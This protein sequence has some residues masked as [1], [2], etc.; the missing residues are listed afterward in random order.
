M[1]FIFVLG[2]VISGLGKGVTASSIGAILNEMGYK[3]TIK[4]LDPYLNVDPGTMNPIEHG[5]VYV[6]NDGGETDLD[7][8][9][10]ERIAEIKA[11]KNNS[12]SSGKLFFELLKKERKG[13]YLGKTVQLIPHFTNMIEEF[14]YRDVDKYDFV[15][16]EIG[17]S[18]GDY[19][20]GPFLECIRRMKKK[21]KN[22]VMICLVSYIVYYKASKESKTKPTQVAV[23][24]LMET[25]NQPDVLFARTEYD[26][27]E[28]VLNK[29]S[30]QT[31]V[32]RENIIEAKN[33]DSIY[34]VPLEYLKYGLDKILYNH[35]NLGK[36]KQLSFDKWKKLSSKIDSTKRTVILGIVGKYVE[37]E[38]AYYSVVEAINHAGWY[39]DAKVNL[40]WINARKSTGMIK[41]LEKVDGV[42]VPG[43]FGTSGMEEIIFAINYCREKRVPFMG[44]CLG[45]QLAVIEFARNILNIK[46]ASSREFGKDK[47]TFIIDLMK[48]WKKDSGV[49]EE[50]S[51]STDLGGTL[52]LGSYQAVI[53]KDSLAHKLYKKE[54][55]NER[56]R[57]RYEVNIDYKK[58]L[59]AKGM[60]ISGISPDGKLPEII[61][62]DQKK[63]DNQFFIAGQFHP[64]F[65]STPFK[66]HPLF[67]GLIK[68]CINARKK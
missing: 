18:V 46:N 42:L 7:L 17:G 23:K 19:E 66:P 15:I 61:E 64:E 52:R 22:D 41:E 31:N 12:I 49:V 56:H 5:E 8:G 2:G 11:S 51:S 40:I 68:A 28:S 32:N 37:L 6:T 26:L 60:I 34:K 43:G 38:D 57:H 21:L 39:Y 4:K 63:F 30:Q 24:L 3:I 48:Q 16:C 25:G 53:K 20:V 29:L 65:N 45:M 55:I 67:K 27:D 54:K 36:A 50:R 1:R 59:E 62:L 10:Y 35:F 14:I 33:V 58:R 9:Y 13:E 44:I 47:D